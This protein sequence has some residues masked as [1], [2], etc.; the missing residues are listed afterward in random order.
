M[1]IVITIIMYRAI[2]KIRS[3]IGYKMGKRIITITTIITSS[4]IV[5]FFLD[6]AESFMIVS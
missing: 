2:S 6:L 5:F 1:I 3:I 4:S